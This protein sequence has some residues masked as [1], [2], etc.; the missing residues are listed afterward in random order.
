[1]VKVLLRTYEERRHKFD[2]DEIVAI[3][4]WKLDTLFAHIR[5]LEA[6][7]EKLKADGKREFV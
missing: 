6:T 7:I 4:V 2:K 1:M 3:Y 5:E